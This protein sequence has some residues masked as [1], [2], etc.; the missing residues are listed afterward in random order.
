MEILREPV[1]STPAPGAHIKEATT[2]TSFIIGKASEVAEEIRIS[3]NKEDEW[4]VR[5]DRIDE[6]Q[7][8]IEKMLAKLVGGK[9]ADVF[10]ADEG[11]GRSV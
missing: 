3:S 8:R 9:Y 7:Q 2:E 5:L 1:Q 10:S 6:R 11:S 4:R